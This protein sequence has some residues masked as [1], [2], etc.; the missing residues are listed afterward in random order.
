MILANENL[1]YYSVY[2]FQ[3]KDLVLVF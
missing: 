3:T 2:F 1:I